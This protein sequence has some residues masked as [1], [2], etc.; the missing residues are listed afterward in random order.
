LIAGGGDR[1]VPL[2][3]KVLVA[4]AVLDTIEALRAEGDVSP[5]DLPGA[6]EAS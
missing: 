4:G 2:A 1:H 6:A 5:D 3:S